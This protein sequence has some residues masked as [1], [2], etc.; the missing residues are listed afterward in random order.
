[1]LGF[2]P[3]D[4]SLQASDFPKSGQILKILLDETKIA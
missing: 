2:L 3:L 4:L 1:L